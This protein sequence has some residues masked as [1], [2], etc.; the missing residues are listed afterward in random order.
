M[1]RA[2]G[3]GTGS[4]G[5][6]SGR[7][8]PLVHRQGPGARRSGHTL[9]GTQAGGT[10]GGLGRVGAQQS[11]EVGTRQAAAVG[12]GGG[13][14]TGPGPGSLGAECHRCPVSARPLGAAGKLQ[15]NWG[16]ALL[17]TICPHCRES[18]VPSPSRSQHCSHRGT[19]L[20]S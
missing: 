20:S 9:T 4:P 19:S 6:E 5:L 11:P 13:S 18:R 3:P 15:G 16:P 14:T 10:D 12:G 17:R 1:A 8:A 7:E 2:R